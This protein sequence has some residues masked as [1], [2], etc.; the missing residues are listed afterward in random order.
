[1]PALF[2]TFGDAVAMV[3]IVSSCIIQVCCSPFN[4][5]LLVNDGAVAELG[6]GV[7][8]HQLENGAELGNVG[9]R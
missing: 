7:Q 6:E 8:L 9:S 1:M 2:S 3:Y 4:G 5:C